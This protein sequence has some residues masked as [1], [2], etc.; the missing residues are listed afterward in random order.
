MQVM[1]VLLSGKSIQNHLHSLLFTKA[2]IIY[3]YLVKYQELT[4][5]KQDQ[6]VGYIKKQLNT[7]L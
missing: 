4:K 7:P 2:F 1:V 6:N 5:L 3:F